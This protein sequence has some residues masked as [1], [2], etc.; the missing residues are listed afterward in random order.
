[1][2]FTAYFYPVYLCTAFFT[3]A[4]DPLKKIYILYFNFENMN[5]IA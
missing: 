2:I 1:M 3:I 4:K 5:I